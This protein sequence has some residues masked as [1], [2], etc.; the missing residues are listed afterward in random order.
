MSLLNSQILQNYPSAQA[1]TGFRYLVGIVSIGKKN[2]EQRGIF[3]HDGCVDRSVYRAMITEAKKAGCSTS[4]L[5]YGRLLTYSG[6]GIDFVSFSE[7]GLT[8]SVTNDKR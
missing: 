5:V 2:Q 4:M 7:A 1:V 8:K 3:V 6:P